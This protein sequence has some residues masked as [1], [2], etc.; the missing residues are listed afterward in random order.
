MYTY[1]YI[2]KESIVGRTL[3]I[4][5]AREELTRLPEELSDH[6]EDGAITVTRRGVPVLAVL[7]WDFYE[8]LIETLEILSDPEQ[9][10][11]LRAGLADALAGRSL[12][13][14]DLEK[15]IGG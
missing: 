4:A 10:A 7:S 3:S 2:S 15:E 11:T 12:S 6:L 5:Q 13:L 9:V 1:M 14:D 8:S